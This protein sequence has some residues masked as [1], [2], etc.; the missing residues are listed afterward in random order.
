MPRE[1]AGTPLTLGAQTLG[2]CTLRY[3]IAQG[4][5]ASVYLAQLEGSA[6]FDK[7][8]AVK[9][10][11]PHIADS[12]RFVN[13]FLDEARLASKLDHPNLCSVLDFGEE[14][15]TWFIAMEY[16]HG[17]TFGVVARNGWSAGDPPSFAMTAHIVADAARGLHAAHELKLPSG[18][19]AGVVHRDVSPENLFVTYAG[20][21]KVVDFGVARW[22][23]QS[24]D[25]TVPGELKGKIA[26]MSPEQLREE[27]VDRRADVWS[28]GVVLWEVTVGRRLFRRKTD[29]ATVAAVLQDHVPRPSRFREGYPPGLEAVVMQALERDLDARFQ[30]A[31]DLARA[32]EQWIASTGVAASTDD[33]AD[34]MQALFAE[35]I[36]C[37]EELLRGPVGDV[38]A[39]VSQLWNSSPLNPADVEGSADH[40]AEPS[41]RRAEALSEE[42]TVARTGLTGRPSHVALAPAAPSSPP[43]P[44]RPPPP[45]VAPPP[46]NSLPEALAHPPRTPQPRPAAQLPAPPSPAAARAHLPAWRRRGGTSILAAALLAFASVG[47]ALLLIDP[48]EHRDIA[49]LRPQPVPPRRPRVPPPVAAEPRPVDAQPSPPPALDVAPTAAPAPPPPVVSAPTPAP[50]PAPVP[51]AHA[52]AP[53]VA[54]PPSALRPPVRPTPAPVPAAAAA[55]AVPAAP[56]YLTFLAVP[57]AD[58]FEGPRPLG[59]T[60]L[61][62]RPIAAGVHVYRFVPGN[63]LAPRFTRVVVRPGASSVVEARWSAP[64]PAPTPAAPAPTP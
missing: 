19:N 42:V 23:E 24:Q 16:L 38:V 54:P 49:P 27:N 15:G 25:R 51:I 44:S 17:E 31:R 50:T 34:Y 6:G 52:P 63:G 60:P 36:E 26:Y 10:I 64:A 62:E 46:R 2:R 41:S 28:L 18:E 4:G 30:S 21:T 58:V 8:V 45:R 59:R 20:L 13:M 9:T 32:L 43:T 29:G 14:Q 61:A 47:V 40:S 33:V 12:V 7:W 39:E 55:P 48:G 35:Q 57:D 22:R 3:R 1:A 53:P 5:M 37:R 56:G 11:H